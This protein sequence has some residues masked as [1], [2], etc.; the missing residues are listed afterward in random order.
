MP[1]EGM[2]GERPSDPHRPAGDGESRKNNAWDWLKAK[3]GKEQIWA[4]PGSLAASTPA[5]LERTGKGEVV[6]EG[7]RKKLA[8]MLDS[9]ALTRANRRRATAIDTTDFEAAFD[10]LVNPDP[11]PKWLDVLADVATLF[12]GGFLGY[13]I[14]IMTGD[15]PDLRMIVGMMLSGL[16]LGIGAIVIK[17]KKIR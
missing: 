16:I 14:N 17:N 12:G 11:R 3:Y 4:K 2:P 13:A 6:R 10:D 7:L 15:A 1:D 8:E 5:S 9:T